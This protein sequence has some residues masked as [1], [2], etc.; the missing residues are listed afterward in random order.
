MSFELDPGSPKVYELKLG[1]GVLAR[2]RSRTPAL[3]DGDRDVGLETRSWFQ[4]RS[5][6]L[7]GLG[8]GL[9]LGQS[10]LSQTLT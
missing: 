6:S 9:G 3:R 1:V 10:R 8:R 7:A 5:K 4:D 2:K